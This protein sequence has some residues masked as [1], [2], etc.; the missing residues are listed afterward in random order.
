MQ[1]LI[2]CS[3]HFNLTNMTNCIPVGLIS[4]SVYGNE[5]VIYIIMSD[6]LM[7]VCVKREGGV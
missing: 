7:T 4:F 6:H 5:V 2:S 1:S 3:I